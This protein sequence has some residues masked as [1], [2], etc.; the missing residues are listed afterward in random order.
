MVT[1]GMNDAFALAQ[2]GLDVWNSLNGGTNTQAEL[3]LLENMFA[4]A[5]K[6]DNGQKTVNTDHEYWTYIQTVF[7]GVIGFEPL[8]S[9]KAGLPST[10]V[11]IY[12]DYSRYTKN[13]DCNGKRKLGYACDT[14]NNQIVKMGA[15]WH[16]C[17]NIK[18]SGIMVRGSPICTY[19]SAHLLANTNNQKGND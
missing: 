6:D 18:T 13:K 17:K 5:V 9:S 4:W 12:C 15:S 19:I 11:I 3:D 10:D 14:D 1:T 8:K 7:T 16:G 2:A